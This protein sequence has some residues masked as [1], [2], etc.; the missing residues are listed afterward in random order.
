LFKRTNIQWQQ[1][2]EYRAVKA[3]MP[4]QTTQKQ[5][6]AV[7]AV[8]QG[9]FKKSR[10]QIEEILISFISFIY[11]FTTLSSFYFVRCFLP[12]LGSEIKFINYFFEHLRI[13]CSS[14]DIIR[15]IFNSIKNYQ[16]FRR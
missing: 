12:V 1:L 8:K 7:C 13:I 10:R 9:G 4:S 5:A 2:R 14:D 16:L 6:W 15:Q 11:L 3:K